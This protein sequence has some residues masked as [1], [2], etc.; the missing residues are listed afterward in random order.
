M[1]WASSRMMKK[2]QEWYPDPPYVLFVSNNE[3]PRLAWNKVEEDRRYLE[4]YGSGRSDEFKRKVVADGWIKCYGAMLRG[5]REGLTNLNWK[6]RVIFVGYDAFGP[7]HFARWPGWMEYSLYSSGRIDPWPQV[8]DGAS[9]SYY[10]FN[11][12]AVTDYTVYSPQVEAMNWVFMLEEAKRQNPK[13]WFELSAWDGHEPEL[14]NDKR[15]TYARAG[16]KY[17]PERYGGMV[18]FGLWLL[19]PRVVREFRGYQDTLAQAEPYFLPI[20]AAVDRVHNNPTLKDFW[21]QGELVVN[22]AHPHPYQASVP[23]EYQ[24]IDRWFLLDTSLDPPH[25]LELGNQL[26][27]F[28]LALV[29]GRAPQR[30]WLVYAHSPLMGRDKVKVTIPD[31]QPVTINVAVAGS[32]YVVDEK[33]RQVQPVKQ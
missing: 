32:F 5:M 15:K 26:P 18:Q 23:K 2:L 21:R 10:V 16:Q 8:W 1:E 28:S 12:S 3:H 29:K 17:T 30:Q 27:V 25:P 9:P 7:P 24:K 19:R 11:W 20:V 33:T 6:Q 13:F 22:R 4:K 31:Y 14:E